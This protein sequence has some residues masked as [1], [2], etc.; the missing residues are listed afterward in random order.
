MWYL[1]TQHI[2]INW[3]RSIS[4]PIQPKQRTIFPKF[5]LNQKT[6]LPSSTSP[7]HL[8]VLHHSSK[9]WGTMRPRL[10]SRAFLVWGNV[11][12]G[13][14]W[15]EIHSVCVGMVKE[16]ELVVGQYW[17][18]CCC[19][20]VWSY[21]YTRHLCVLCDWGLDIIYSLA[22]IFSYHLKVDNIVHSLW[23]LFKFMENE[24]TMCV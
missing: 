2:Q 4:N 24:S 3:L 17:C 6:L 12:F 13:W 15:L 11:E 20:H 10:A 1:S 14:A 18:C 23:A 16:S 7:C 21:V 22:L 9:V 5:L 19:Q 8:K